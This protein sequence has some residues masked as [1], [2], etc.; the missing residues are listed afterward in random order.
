MSSL[1]MDGV[2]PGMLVAILPTPKEHKGWQ[3]SYTGMAAMGMPMAGPPPDPYGPLTGRAFTVKSVCLPFAVLQAEGESPFPV[4]LLRVGLMEVTQDYA[5]ALG[6][7]Q[8][9]PARGILPTLPAI[10]EWRERFDPDI[11]DPGLAA[12]LRTMPETAR[13][14]RKARLAQA[15]KDLPAGHY[16]G[17]CFM[18]GGQVWG[19]IGFPSLDH[20]REWSRHAGGKVWCYGPKPAEE[21]GESTSA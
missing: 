8:D 6:P 5:A 4:H 2:M 3:D 10:I 11:P 14:E 21:H 17:E 18:S 19:T 1:P 9:P 13:A 12:I 7:R 20:A 16:L 15:W